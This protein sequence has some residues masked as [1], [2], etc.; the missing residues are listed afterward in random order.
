MILGAFTFF[1]VLISLV[2]IGTGF[3][4][5]YGLLTSR[6]FNGWTS[7]FL[8]TTVATS[9]TG[10]LFPIHGLTP[11]HVLGILS[12]IAL[13]FAFLG[14]SRLLRDGSWRKTYIITAML[15]LYFN[16]FV[17][18]AQMFGK[19]PALK[20]LAPKGS[21]PPFQVAQLVVLIFFVVVTIRATMKFHRTPLSAT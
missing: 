17:L 14:R 7:L 5:L 15:A 19:I 20:E 8:W 4:V 3:I 12:L 21:E 1:H 6:W 13:T 2:G 16:V 10:F 11:G 9:V 18:V